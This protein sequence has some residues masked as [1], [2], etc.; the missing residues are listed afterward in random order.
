M[1]LL[2]CWEGKGGAIEILLYPKE[3]F[4]KEQKQGRISFFTSSL[5]MKGTS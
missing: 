2:E 3:A 5:E 1:L 4:L